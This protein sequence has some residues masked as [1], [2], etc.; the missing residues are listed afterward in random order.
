MDLEHKI[1]NFF[2]IYINNLHSNVKI[3]RTLSG[4]RYDKRII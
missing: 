4:N 1:M 3:F 2:L